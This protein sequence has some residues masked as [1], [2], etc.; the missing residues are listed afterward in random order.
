M[1]QMNYA[2]ITDHSR[3]QWIDLGV[4][5]D[6]CMTR[7]ETCGAAGGAVSLWMMMVDTDCNDVG[8]I[9]TS[10]AYTP[11]SIHTTGFGLSCYNR[12]VG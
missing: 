12:K 10:Y 11:G 2:V 5:T 6:A 9:I 3:K 8:G 1:F 7:P 4:H